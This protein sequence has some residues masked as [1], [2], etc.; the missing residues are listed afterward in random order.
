MK[1]FSKEK[2]WEVVERVFLQGDLMTL[3]LALKEVANALWKKVLREEMTL[4]DS[5]K[6]IN[7]LKEGVIVEI[8]PGNAY[9]EEGFRIAVRQKSS[10][11]DSL[12]IALAKSVGGKLI[13]SDLMQRNAG[14][15]EGI[16]VEVI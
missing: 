2:G 6:L 10:I 9:L 14:I 16:E 15:N 1:Y 5:L 7:T 11:Y 4:E 13:T 8:V 12:F 3:D